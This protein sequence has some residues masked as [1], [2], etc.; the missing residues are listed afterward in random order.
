M[1]SGT[2]GA[3]LAARLTED[4][5]CHVLV[6]E[7]GGSDDNF[8][9]KLPVGYFRSI[10][11]NR[12][13]HLYRGE[14]DPGISG[15][16]MDV[17]RGRVL[18]GSSSINGL[19]FIR[20]QVEDFDDWEK[21][22]AQGWSYR[23]VL[24]YFRNIEAYDGA[25]N[26]FRGGYGPVGVSNLRNKN[27]A[28][29]AWKQAAREYGLPDNPDFNGDDTY[30][31][32]DY[33]LTLRGR[34]R[35]SAATAFLQPAMQRPNFQL[36]LNANALRLIYDG[37]M[38]VGVEYQQNGE[39]KSAYAERE[40]IL[41][42][43]AIQS[44]QLLQL[45][46]IGPA[47]LLRKH[48]IKV[49]VDAPEVGSNLQDHL[50]M[51]T[52]VEL[53]DPKYSLNSQVRNP[54]RLAEMGY[55]WL[56][57][58]KGPLTVGAGQVGGATYTK[59]SNGKRPDIQIF[60]MP[61]SVDKPG[62]P[63]HKYP[64]FTV[65]YWQCHPESR[66]NIS[67][68]SADPFDDP[69]IVTNYLSTQKDC[70]VMVEGLR[71]VREIYDKPAFKNLW[72]REIIPGSDFESDEEILAAIRKHASTVYHPVGTC[73]MG[74]DAKSV[75]DP[76]LRVRGVTGLRVVD[77]SVMPRI[78]SANTNAATFMIGEKAASIIKTGI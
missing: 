45:N 61:L 71:V 22:G 41:S 29:E 59:F 64:G 63:L 47:E 31:V 32:G 27:F 56:F 10:Y 42:A 21:L 16:R 46:G 40:I 28:C 76:E 69:K 74:N 9:L 67:I 3:T 39:L 44:P 5:D 62:M 68:N 72:Q 50:Q 12:V 78:V 36:E 77:A 38:V 14:A 33:Q 15:R 73:R 66:G 23:D 13:S 70:E 17:P 1:G 26:Q 6:L 11:D 25:P 43:G 34:W 60:V 8:W 75:V 19:I 51:R 30:G 2:A 49:K 18:G 20:G 57:A 24:P 52:I 58:G 35:E 4:K 37:N 55:Q 48:D 53:A 54:L 65:S 7:A